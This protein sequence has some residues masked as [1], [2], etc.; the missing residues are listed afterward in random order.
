M[1]Y[2]TYYACIITIYK[3]I[4]CI[5]PSI[6]LVIYFSRFNYFCLIIKYYLFNAINYKWFS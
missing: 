3:L 6:N 1:C 4:I 2:N 5:V